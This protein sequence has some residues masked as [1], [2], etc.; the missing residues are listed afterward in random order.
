MPNNS[1]EFTNFITEALFL[2]FMTTESKPVPP[3]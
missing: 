2:V 1:R 3:E